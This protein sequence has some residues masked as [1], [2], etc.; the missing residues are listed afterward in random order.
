MTD[1]SRCDE[2][3]KKALEMARSDYAER[4][5]RLQAMEAEVNDHRVKMLHLSRLILALSDQ[6]NEPLTDEF[7]NELT[8]IASIC[9]TP[10]RKYVRRKT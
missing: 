5:E 10:K 2:I 1:F 9:S 7:R 3:C 8:A 4:M 6:L